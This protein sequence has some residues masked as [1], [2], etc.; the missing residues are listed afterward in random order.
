VKTEPTFECSICKQ[1]KPMS[2]GRPE[3]FVSGPVDEMIKLKHPDWDAN[4]IICQSCLRDFRHEY[5]TKAIR[6]QVGEI[7]AVEEEVLE[8]LKE[9]EVLVR[10]TDLEFEEAK[11]F[12]QRLA[13][14]VAAFGG[15]WRFIIFFALAFFVWITINGIAL[16]HKPFDPYPYILLNLVLSC[17]AALQAPIIMMSQNRQEAK[18]RLRS[19]NDYQINLKA[20]IEIRQLHTKMDQLINH[21]WQ[22]LLDIQRLQVDLMEEMASKGDNQTKKS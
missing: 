4:D 18:D 14:R 15:S 7:S 8:S 17:L 2:E 11:T 13:D 21:S 6:E 22:R 9:H 5:L 10:N 16:F 1:K 3:Q 19:E 12:G 20:E